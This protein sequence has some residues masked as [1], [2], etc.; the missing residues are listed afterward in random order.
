MTHRTP[1][2]V[3]IDPDTGNP[4]W[5]PPPK[6]DYRDQITYHPGAPLVA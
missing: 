6:V 5:I 2:Q 3:H 4:I 1:W